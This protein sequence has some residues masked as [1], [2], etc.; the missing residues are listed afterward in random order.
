L[1]KDIGFLLRRISNIA[2]YRAL[3]ATCMAWACIYF[4]AVGEVNIFCP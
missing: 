2:R 1:E 3:L 4:E